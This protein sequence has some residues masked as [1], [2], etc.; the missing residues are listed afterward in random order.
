MEIRVP[1]TQN[2]SAHLQ[3]KL[4]VCYG[5]HGFPYLRQLFSL[6]ETHFA[7]ETR[8]LHTLSTYNASGKLK[9]HLQIGQDA[10]T[11]APP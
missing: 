6:I 9:P 1:R 10:L 7:K 2:N 3:P 4:V 11:G 8:Q 5:I